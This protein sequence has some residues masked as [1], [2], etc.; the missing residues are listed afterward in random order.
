MK[1]RDLLKAALAMPFSAAVLPGALAPAWAAQ[2]STAGGRSRVRPGDSA[3]PSAARWDALKRNVDG[4][5]LKLQSPFASRGATPTEA[6]GE[7]LKQLKNPYY[8]GDEVAL[9]QTVAGSRVAVATERLRGRRA[10]RPPTS[11]PR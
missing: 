2:V 5:L 8:V 11:S 4:R 7:A 1:R 10:S 3:W 6:A 9:T